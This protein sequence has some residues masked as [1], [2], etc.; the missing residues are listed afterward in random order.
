MARENVRPGLGADPQRVA[1]A[2]GDGE[3]A[4]FALA[5]EQGVG[6]DG[7]PH[8]HLA[9]HAAP[10]GKN[11]L[12]RF[13]RGVFI[14]ARIVGQQLFDPQGAVGRAGDDVGEGPAA[15]DRK[16]PPPV[17]VRHQA[18][19]APGLNCE[20]YPLSVDGSGG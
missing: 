13:Q 9:N 14:L 16:V 19:A 10:G 18:D 15:I 8:A 4:A 17:H 5:L 12:N 11:P 6:G 2:A 1:E 3:A 20:R 7:R